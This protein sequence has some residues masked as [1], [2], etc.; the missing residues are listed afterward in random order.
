[1]MSSSMAIVEP[2]AKIALVTGADK[3]IWKEVA[4]Q[5]GQREYLSLV[6]SRD[7]SRGQAAGPAA[8]RR[9]T[10]GRADHHRR[11]RPAQ[12]RHSR[13]TIDRRH[14]RLDALINNA[15]IAIDDAPPSTV[16][17]DVLRTTYETASSVCSRSPRRCRLCS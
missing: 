9:R 8:A 6:G 5:L 17:V 7:E 4:R 1:M 16:G 15:A 3:G 2:S 13:L 10:L 14:G 11:D 12:H